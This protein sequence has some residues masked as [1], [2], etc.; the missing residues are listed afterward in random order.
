[1]PGRHRDHV[2]ERAADLD[3]DHVAVGVEAE[4]ARAEPALQRRRPARRR[5]RDH[6]G[7]GLPSAT[8][9]AN[10][11]PDS[12]A[13]RARRPALGQRPRSCAGGGPDR[14]PWSPR[15][16][17]PTRSPTRPAPPRRTPTAPRSRR[18]RPT[19]TAAAAS[20]VASIAPAASTSGRYQGFRRRARIAST[21]SA[22][23][24]PRA[25]PACRC[26]PRWIAS[27]VPQLPAPTIGDH[28]ASA[29]AASAGGLG[30]AATRC[31]RAAARCWRGA[32]PTMIAAIAARP[33]HEGRADSRAAPRRA[34]RTTRGQQRAERDVAERGDDRHEDRQR[35]QRS[36]AAPARA[37]RRAPSPRPCRR[38]SRGTPTSSCRP[39]RPPPRRRSRRRRRP[40]SAAPST[41]AR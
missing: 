34:A 25:A 13:T 6:R 3:A 35:G 33:R 15:P 7:G 14:S 24:A 16:P 10:V 5:G 18:P 4:L 8:S 39:P 19:A 40:P 20:A 22:L 9:R 30:P 28:D 21:T 32:A 12:T 26:A 27:A 11:G 41:T 38:G 37:A 23:R 29:D 31:P 1:M 17:A 36:P 2:L